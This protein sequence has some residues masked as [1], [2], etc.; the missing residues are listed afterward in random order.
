MCALVNY[1]DIVSFTSKG[2]RPLL[3]SKNLIIFRFNFGIVSKIKKSQFLMETEILG[4]EHRKY[5][6]SFLA[7][8]PSAYSSLD[9]SRL[10]M[11]YFACSALDILQTDIPN[12]EEVIEFVYSNQIDEGGGFIGSSF[13][14]ASKYRFSHVTMTYC[15]IL[16]L[17]LL[18]DDLSRVNKVSIVNGLKHLQQDDGC[19]QA[20]EFGTESDMRFMYSACGVSF[21]LQDW[22]GIN[23]DKA[24][25]FI[26]SSMRFDGGFGILP[27]QESHCG[28]IYTAVSS[29]VLL[30][31][32]DQCDELDREYLIKFLVNRQIHGFNGRI[33]KVPDSCYTFW[34]GGAL[35]GLGLQDLM[36]ISSTR[37]FL[38]ECQFTRG[39]FSK[40]PHAYPDILHAY[41]S[42]AGLSL[43]H[44]KGL[45]PI[46]SVVGLTCRA[47]QT[48]LQGNPNPISG[49]DTIF[50]GVE[51]LT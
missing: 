2:G 16:T 46:E 42:V 27:D 21:L 18:G 48:W 36:D 7:T 8:V 45:A 4:D 14:G 30:G 37:R 11:V 51:Q 32:L 12:K 33:N 13:S 9:T 43:L 34:A 47:F 17:V 15:A 44:E 22:S 10:L 40:V 28:A 3:P 5:F 26:L 1:N 25:E 29:L 41:C 35:Q 6:L 38:L 20:V 39:G 23:V 24:T 19:F 31:R 50:Q 49:S